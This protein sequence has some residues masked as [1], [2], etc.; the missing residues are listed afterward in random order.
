MRLRN[1]AIILASGLS[2]ASTPVLA[3]SE[4]MRAGAELAQPSLQDDGDDDDGGFNSDWIVPGII[5]IGVIITL[6]LIYTED[7]DKVSP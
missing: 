2:L 3:Q 5:I 7:D 4:G 1:A 6:F